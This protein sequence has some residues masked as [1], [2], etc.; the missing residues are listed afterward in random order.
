MLQE[1]IRYSRN[2]QKN[3]INKVL[4][5]IREGEHIFFGVARCN[6]SAGDNFD[7]KLGL[8]IAKAR[9]QKAKESP[10]PKALETQKISESKSFFPYGRV[11]LL[12]VKDL[13][14]YFHGLD[15][16]HPFAKE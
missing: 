5:T 8:K 7:K 9:A 12:E 16:Y 14:Q 3:A 11:P 4:F 15:T 6:L 1:Q 10:L 2:K 13:L